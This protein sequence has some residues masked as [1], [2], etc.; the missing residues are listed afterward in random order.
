MTF[1]SPRC[2]LT[3]SR[4]RKT[5]RRPEARN[6][7][8]MKGAEVTMTDHA[9]WRIEAKKFSMER[10]PYPYKLGHPNIS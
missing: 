5:F 6:P 4:G 1:L 3:K 2:F 8:S 10:T 9:P 7:K